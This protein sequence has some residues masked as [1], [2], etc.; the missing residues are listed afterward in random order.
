MKAVIIGGGIAGLS[1]GIFAQKNG[2]ESVIYEKNYNTG[3]AA[4][5]IRVNEQT[6]QP[7][8]RWALYGE[9][10]SFLRSVWNEVGI[11]EDIFIE[12]DSFITVSHSGTSITL[13]KDLG[14][15]EKELYRLSPDDGKGISLFIKGVRSCMDLEWIFSR[16]YE[17]FCAKE[18]MAINNMF[19]SRFS[20]IGKYKRKSGK[21]FAEFF[22]HP[23]L[24]FLFHALVGEN[25]SIFPFL[26]AYGQYCAGK[27]RFVRHARN[28]A[29]IMTDTYRQLNGCLHLVQP[30]NKIEI[31]DNKA[32]GVRL[33]NGKFVEADVVI[34]ACDSH[35]L[36]RKLLPNKNCIPF[37]EKRDRNILQ[38]PIRSSLLFTYSLKSEMKMLPSSLILAVKG[39]IA[40]TQ[41]PKSIHVF[42]S[43]NNADNCSRLQIMI[44]QNDLDYAYWKRLSRTPKEYASQ[45]RQLGE[46][47]QAQICH[48]MPE[49]DGNITLQEAL[50]PIDFYE[51]FA[52]ETGAFFPY[53]VMPKAKWEFFNGRIETIHS[54]LLAGQWTFPLGGVTSACLSGQ[55]A[56]NRILS[57]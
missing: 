37:F 6:I 32:V 33:E 12:N 4:S 44:E 19:A 46:T 39:L 22:S 15:L 8:V 52:G 28:I 27:L 42:K 11:N 34:S 45:L 51:S 29:Q 13:W 18:K 2:L 49:L 43:I 10:H 26:F 3:G 41:R 36:S 17:F 55:F 48:L 50:T 54:L 5:S 14:R 16:P 57:Q 25:T 30:V 23:S 56:I 47:T 31:Q 24:R 53:A 20:T 7:P 1:A 9:E 38:Y 40:A 35:I 21:D